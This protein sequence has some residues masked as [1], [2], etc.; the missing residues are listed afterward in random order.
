MPHCTGLITTKHFLTVRSLRRGGRLYSCG[1]QGDAADV[2][3]VS[4]LASCESWQS[5]FDG[6]HNPT[7][8]WGSGLFT[9]ARKGWF[10][11]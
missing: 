4:E 2:L 9:V 3:Q 5:Y 8:L 10:Q 1:G 7:F 6:F 11:C